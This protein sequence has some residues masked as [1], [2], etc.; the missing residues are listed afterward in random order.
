MAEQPAFPKPRVIVLDVGNV[1]IGL[2]FS[3]SRARLENYFSAAEELAGARRWISETEEKYGLGLMTT[4][5]FVAAARLALGMG[6]ERFVTLWNDIFVERAYMSLF[7]Q[8]LREQGYVLALCSNTNEL[9]A[10][11]F[12][13][14]Y[15]YFK[16]IH[17]SIFSHVV[18]ALK[19]DPAIYRAVEAA[20]GRPA[21]EHL[22]LDDLPENVAGA[23]TLGWDAICF[24]SPEQVQA[25]LRARGITF[26]P[27]NVASER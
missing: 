12:Q 10:D 23:R 11:Y 22:F 3:R 24:E 13:E 6:R 16:Y 18:H 20:T 7:V 8:E 17:Y 19:P 15:P 25:E 27:W 9:H 1:L 4:E 21:A 14:R 5:E 26:S 2:D